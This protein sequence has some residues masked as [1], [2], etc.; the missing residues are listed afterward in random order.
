[1]VMVMPPKRIPMWGRIRRLSRPGTK[2]VRAVAVPLLI[3][4]LFPHNPVLPQI[5]LHLALPKPLS[6]MCCNADKRDTA[7]PLRWRYT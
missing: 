7:E 2:S 6:L 1:M 4:P 3:W 5:L